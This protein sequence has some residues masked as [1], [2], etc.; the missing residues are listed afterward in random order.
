MRRCEPKV[1]QGLVM[2]QVLDQLLQGLD[3]LLQGL[4]ATCVA[5][6]SQKNHKHNSQELSPKNQTVGCCTNCCM[7]KSADLCSPGKLECLA[8]KNSGCERT[9]QRKKLERQMSNHSSSSWMTAMMLGRFHTNWNTSIVSDRYGQGSLRKT[10]SIATKR[11]ANIG[12]NSRTSTSQQACRCSQNMTE[13]IP[14]STM[15]SMSTSS[16]NPN[17]LPTRWWF[18]PCLS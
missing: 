16:S 4:E 11:M 8:M 7:Y 1:G 5:Q 9:I 2:P 6:Q 17:S 12:T 18:F 15:E 14:M 10:A 3:Q 13:S